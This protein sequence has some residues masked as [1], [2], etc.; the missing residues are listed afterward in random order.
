MT[1]RFLISCPANCEDLLRNEVEEAGGLNIKTRVRSVVFDGDAETGYRLCLRSRIGNAL[2]R[3]L[4]EGHAETKAEITALA[5]TVPWESVFSQEQ[6]FSVLCK[7]AA[8]NKTEIVHS[9]PG[10]FPSRSRREESPG[11]A[12]ALHFSSEDFRGRDGPFCIHSCSS[13][14]FS[15]YWGLCK[16]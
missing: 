5:E 10:H 8:N 16:R 13:C 1:H 14:L 3:I 7:T 15:F 12:P 11:S 9:H 6:S 2:I 4:A